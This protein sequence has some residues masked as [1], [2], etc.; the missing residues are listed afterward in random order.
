M[1]DL[2]NSRFAIIVYAIIKNECAAVAGLP[3]QKIKDTKL[4]DKKPVSL[5]TI[6]GATGI[7]DQNAVCLVSLP[8]FL[9][10]MVPNT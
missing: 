10:C 2:N 6:P 1:V 7:T 5:P 3:G 8:L 9:A 4:P